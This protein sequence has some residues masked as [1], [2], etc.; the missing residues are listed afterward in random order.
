MWEYLSLEEYFMVE[1]KFN[2]KVFSRITI[3]KQWKNKHEKVF[4]IESKE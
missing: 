4:S 3:E 2:E 1:E